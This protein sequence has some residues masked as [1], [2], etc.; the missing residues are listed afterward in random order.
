MAYSGSYFGLGLEESKGRVALT[1]GLGWAWQDRTGPEMG[2]IPNP[3][4]IKAVLNETFAQY[5]R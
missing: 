2:S 1:D 3:A 5:N 4:S